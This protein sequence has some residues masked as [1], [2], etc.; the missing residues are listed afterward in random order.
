MKLKKYYNKIAENKKKMKY[1]HKTN[2][3]TNLLLQRPIENSLKKIVKNSLLDVNSVI[4]IGCGF[5]N[6][7]IEGLHKNI[8]LVVINDLSKNML[9]LTKINIKD[10]FPEINLI[11]IQKDILKKNISNIPASPLVLCIGVINHYKG[12]KLIDLLRILSEISTKKIL[13]S[14]AHNDFL[15]YKKVG[16]ILRKKNLPYFIHQ[17]SLI[18][19]LMLKNGFKCKTNKYPIINKYLS[20]IVFQLFYT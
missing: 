10:K 11:S 8:S 6:Y 5:C 16:N 19:N 7:L 14:Y 4:D 1:Y 20:P 17:S 3:F 18:T 13:I 2:F 12:E 15:L 9:E